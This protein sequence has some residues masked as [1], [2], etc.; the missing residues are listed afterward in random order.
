MKL[1]ID[2]RT[3]SDDV[4]T[5]IRKM[6]LNGT[7]KPGERINQVQ[8]AEQMEISRGPLREALRL[9]QNEGLV[10]HETNK[11]A[12]VTTLSQQD[13][14]EIYTLRALLEGE[15][16]KLAADHLTNQDFS[17]MLELLEEFSQALVNQDLE[18]EARVDILFH[19]TIVNASKHQRLIKMH[20][21]LDTQVGAMF[22]TVANSLPKR[23][24]KVVENHRLLLDVLQGGSPLDIQE[25]IT[26]HY[27]LALKDLKEVNL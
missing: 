17:R 6:I 20:E 23:A 27:L 1:R 13:V 18:K 15:A 8:L 2:H 12:F 11:G 7:L 16:A 3:L 25:V 5:L 4:A 26:N 21:Q 24:R 14:Y 22:F 10:K 9:L 19:R